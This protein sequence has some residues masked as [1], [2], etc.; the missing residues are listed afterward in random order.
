LP[1]LPRAKTFRSAEGAEKIPLLAGVSAETRHARAWPFR[2]RGRRPD[3]PFQDND[4][5]FQDNDKPDS[6]PIWGV[7]GR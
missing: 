5:P 7:N 1:P 3:P 4:P 2:E 6:W